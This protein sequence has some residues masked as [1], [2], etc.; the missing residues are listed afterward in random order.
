MNNNN[1]NNR[2]SPKAKPS[3]LGKCERKGLSP[4]LIS[5]ILTTGNRSVDVTWDYPTH[6]GQRGRKWPFWSNGTKGS[7]TS[8]VG[9]AD[10]ARGRGTTLGETRVSKLASVLGLSGYPGFGL[11]V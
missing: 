5:P 4:S 8:G 11:G 9:R 10:D 2:E 3:K 6:K 1:N 7:R